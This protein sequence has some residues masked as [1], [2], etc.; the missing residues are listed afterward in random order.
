MN[1]SH[2]QPERFDADHAWHV[3]LRLSGPHGLV[4]HPSSMFV[5]HDVIDAAALLSFL[6]PELDVIVTRH[7][8]LRVHIKRGVVI[9]DNDDF[10]KFYTVEDAGDRELAFRWATLDGALDCGSPVGAHISD[11]Y[12]ALSRTRSHRHYINVSLD[13][14][15][16][17]GSGAPS[18]HLV[19]SMQDLARTNQLDECSWDQFLASSGLVYR[20]FRVNYNEDGE[21]C[22]YDGNSYV[23]VSLPHLRNSAM[24]LGAG[25]ANWHTLSARQF[26][27]ALGAAR[28]PERRASRFPF[29]RAV[30]TFAQDLVLAIR[31]DPSLRSDESACG[32]LQAL[33][34]GVTI[35]SRSRI[36]VAPF[37]RAVWELHDTLADEIVASDVE[38]PTPC[39]ATVT[40]L[41]GALAKDTE[42]LLVA[43]CIDTLARIIATKPMGSAAAELSLLETRLRSC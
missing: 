8:R 24:D 11:A 43:S 15:R 33:L 34:D 12:A 32:S 4:N 6:H 16:S 22:G 38:R 5:T 14:A 30:S 37:T 26:L 35:D 19:T 17:F 18:L 39:V 3:E 23:R 1:L 27:T 7:A 21:P 20:W 29:S 31:S 10:E 36:D 41:E 28:S 25:A 2:A 9:K 40:R 42:F 13:A